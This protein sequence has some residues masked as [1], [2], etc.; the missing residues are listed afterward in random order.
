[1]TISITAASARGTPQ[2]VIVTGELP[3]AAD[4]RDML[5]FICYFS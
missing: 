4:T 2:I 1:M 5:S 3:I